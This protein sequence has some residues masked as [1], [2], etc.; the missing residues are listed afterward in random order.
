MLSAGVHSSVLFTWPMTFDT[1]AGWANHADSAGE[2]VLLPPGSRPYPSDPEGGP[3][4]WIAFEANVTSVPEGCPATATFDPSVTA[5]QIADWMAAR[6][7]LVTSQPRPASGGGLPGVVID[8][9]MAADAPPECF[10]FPAVMLIHGLPPSDYDQGI[11]SGT[12]MRF[13]FLDRGAE[14]LMIELDDVSGGGRLDELSAIVDTVD[15]TG[16]AS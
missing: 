7:H 8:V 16:P 10:P 14:L 13:Y 2:Y 5:T 9:R 1:P 3:R 6:A 4:D 12:A 15:W 11:G